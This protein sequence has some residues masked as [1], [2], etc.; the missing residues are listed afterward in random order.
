M[1]PAK[2]LKKKDAKR[3]LFKKLACIAKI[4]GIRKKSWITLG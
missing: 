3:T 4:S 1:K 2:V